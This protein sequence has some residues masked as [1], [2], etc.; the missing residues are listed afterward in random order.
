MTNFHAT[1]MLDINIV[2]VYRKVRNLAYSFLTKKCPESRPGCLEQ[3][4]GSALPVTRRSSI[5]DAHESMGVSRGDKDQQKEIQYSSRIICRIAFSEAAT[6]RR[7]RL[8]IWL[9]L[10]CAARSSGSRIAIVRTRPC[11]AIGTANNSCTTL[12]GISRATEA[13]TRNR[14]WYP[15]AF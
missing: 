7:R 8:V 9:N 4:G 14:A 12:R 5:A 15:Q 13:S 10:R 11:R 3:G 1:L 2:Y 6:G